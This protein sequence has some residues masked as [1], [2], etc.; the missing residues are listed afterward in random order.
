MLKKYPGSCH[1][2]AVRFEVELD[3]SAGTTKCNCSICT[4]MRLW[5]SQVRPEAFHLIAGESELTDYQGRSQVAHHVFCRN[6]GVR[7]F[8]WVEV[9]NL[10]GHKY[11]SINLMCLDGVNLDELVAAPVSYPDGRNNNWG[12][13]AQETRHL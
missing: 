10:S 4:K 1:C 2:G 8:E 11:F 13:Q 3:I 6:C 7:S 9:P 5:S 12:S